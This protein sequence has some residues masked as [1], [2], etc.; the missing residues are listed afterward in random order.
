MGVFFRYSKH[1]KNWK[2]HGEN[3]HLF[4]SFGWLVGCFCIKVSHTHTH[5]MNIIFFSS[6]LY[7]PTR[8]F[9]NKKKI[10]SLLAIY[11]S[12]CVFQMR[13]ASDWSRAETKNKKII[14]MEWAIHNRL[15]GL[16]LNKEK[17]QTFISMWFMWF[18]Q[19]KKKTKIIHFDKS[20]L[21]LIW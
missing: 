13:Y 3:H 6:H 19:K 14:I 12:L 17:H 8:R 5:T 11:L 15:W 16:C 2:R 21:R 18:K 9:F 4:S 7:L 1:K 20:S 10:F